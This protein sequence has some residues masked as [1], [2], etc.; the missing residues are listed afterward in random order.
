MY[1]K[2]VEEF[3]LRSEEEE[4]QIFM[5]GCGKM[6]YCTKHFVKRLTAHLDEDGNDQLIDDENITAISD[7]N[8]EQ[9]ENGNVD[10]NLKVVNEHVIIDVI[11]FGE[12]QLI[13]KEDNA[14]KIE[15]EDDVNI[16][17]EIQVQ[18]KE[19]CKGSFTDYSSED[20]CSSIYIAQI[21][22]DPEYLTSVDHLSF[23]DFSR[24]LNVELDGS[25]SLNGACFT[26]EEFGSQKQ[27]SGQ[28]LRGL[29]NSSFT[30]YSSSS[31]QCTTNSSLKS[32]ESCN[33]L[34]LLIANVKAH[35]AILEC[36]DNELEC[37]E[38]F[39]D[40]GYDFFLDDERFTKQRLS[41]VYKWVEQINKSFLFDTVESFVEPFYDLI[42]EECDLDGEDGKKIEK[43]QKSLNVLEWIE[44]INN[45]EQF[46]QII[47]SFVENNR[48]DS[49]VKDIDKDV[50]TKMSRNK[51]RI[52]RCFS[53][54][55][56]KVLCFA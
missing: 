19:L 52:R 11:K 27:Q 45:V 40:Y 50:E 34:D 56:K 9:Q 41:T 25:V 39:S 8:T 44:T 5:P 43:Q 51:S 14:S 3:F 30:D 20:N 22:E 32:N 18:P 1:I 12:K 36:M 29:C 53:W 23:G 54:M 31:K 47:K 7:K 38:R 15:F 10:R 16:V 13:G 42:E 4:R 33:N 24:D 46:D 55:R 48:E 28:K 26:V 49:N 37:S 35:E 6:F 21:A 2:N 17:N